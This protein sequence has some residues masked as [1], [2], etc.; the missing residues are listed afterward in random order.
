MSAYRFRIRAAAAAALLLLLGA[1]TERLDAAR[2]SAPGKGDDP[3]RRAALAGDVAAQLSLA[4][5]FFFGT[6][7]RQANPELAAWWYRKAAE[8]GSPEGHYNFGACLEHG[9]GVTRSLHG[10]LREYRAAEKLPAARFRMARLLLAGIPEEEGE[11]SHVLAAIPPAPVRAMAEL[12]RLAAEGYA[13]ARLELVRILMRERDAAPAREPDPARDAELRRLAESAASAY[14]ASPEAKVFCARLRRRGIGGALD[15]AGARRLLEEAVRAGYAPAMTMLAAEY[16]GA[17]GVPPDPKRALELYTRAADAGEPGALCWMGRQHLIGEALPHD[18]AAAR[19]LFERAAAKD[20]PPGC[21]LLG[22]ALRFGY[23]GAPDPE[24]AFQSYD[25]GARLGDPGAQ[26]R[27]GHC[28]LRG[29]GVAADPTAAVFWFKCAGARGNLEAVR[30]LGVALINGDGVPADPAEGMK[31]LQ[32]AAANGDA[33]AR[34][35]LER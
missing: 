20:Y 13:P 12:R 31:L 26:Q 25:R 24:A 16:D 6:P 15:E 2:E 29:I 10:A 14:G 7:A 17:P 32:A 33:I 18:P 1:G 23:G 30:E 35:L 21:T 4:R 22:D 19:K 28:Y 27:L 5:E 8:Q 9:W 11:H 34:R 3:L